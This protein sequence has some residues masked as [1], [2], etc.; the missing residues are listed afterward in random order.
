[1][2]VDLLAHLKLAGR[3][4]VLIQPPPDSLPEEKGRKK[5]KLSW[6]SVISPHTL[7]PEHSWKAFV[8][9]ILHF[10]TQAIQDVW[11]EECVLGLAGD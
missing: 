7:L 1:M 11:S 8:E 3:P 4:E 2:L 6:G 9:N 10:I 5:I